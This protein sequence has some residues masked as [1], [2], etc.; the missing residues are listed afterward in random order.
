M[1]WQY[2]VPAETPGGGHGRRRDRASGPSRTPEARGGEL[3][4]GWF[5]IQKA[6]G[7]PAGDETTK[8]LQPHGGMRLI[9]LT[10]NVAVS[11]RGQG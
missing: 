6:R 10:E 2:L 4:L 9:R 1:P 5:F 3:I 11:C 8:G 7:T